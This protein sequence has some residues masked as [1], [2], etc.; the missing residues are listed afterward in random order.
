MVNL[1]IYETANDS[2]FFHLCNYMKHMTVVEVCYV[3]QTFPQNIFHVMDI[4]TH[5][6]IV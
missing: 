3:N 5:R 6:V 1:N 2:I 4:N